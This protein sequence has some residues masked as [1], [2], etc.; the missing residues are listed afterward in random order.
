M[1]DCNNS[2]S[3]NLETCNSN[4]NAIEPF[5]DFPESLP[6][7]NDQILKNLPVRTV[8]TENNL[9]VIRDDQFDE[10]PILILPENTDFFYCIREQPMDHLA[11]FNNANEQ[12]F[13]DSFAMGVSIANSS[14]S[15]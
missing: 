13:A 6:D 15:G 12:A 5:L 1:N 7:A 4:F 10:V 11:S 2:V 9:N 8:N 3:S 14:I